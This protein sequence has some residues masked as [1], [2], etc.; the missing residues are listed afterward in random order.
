MSF[1]KGCPGSGAIREPRP[2]E[3]KCT[4][5][6]KVEIWSDEASTICK[7]CKKEVKREMLP[8]CLD[9]CAMARECV[10]DIKYRKY[11]KAKKGRK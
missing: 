7:K 2:E 1:M 10:G 3:I 8:T 11:Q 5:G 6:A 9:W 4:C